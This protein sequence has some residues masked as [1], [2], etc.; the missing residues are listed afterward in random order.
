LGVYSGPADKVNATLNQ[1]AGKDYDSKLTLSRKRL[2]K[3]RKPFIL[4]VRQVSE[5]HSSRRH[6]SSAADRS[7]TLGTVLTNTDIVQMQKAGL[8]E[9]VILSKIG[10]PQLT[11]APAPKT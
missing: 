1:G 2:R 3:A 6:A 7:T 11:S 10:A 9:E 5:N 4:Q 8:S